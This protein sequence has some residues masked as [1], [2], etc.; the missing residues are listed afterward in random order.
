[1]EKA[2]KQST[3]YFKSNKKMEHKAIKIEQQDEEDDAGKQQQK[4]PPKKVT[5]SRGG[6]ERD[7][8]YLKTVKSMEELNNYR[9]EVI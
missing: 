1:L 2:N 9:L 8:N 4:E 7:Y 3:R 6:Q 5:I